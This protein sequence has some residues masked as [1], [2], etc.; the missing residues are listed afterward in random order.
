MTR[1]QRI[2]T[3]EYFESYNLLIKDYHHTQQVE[4]MNIVVCGIL[5]N[6]Q[7]KYLLNQR[8]IVRKKVDESNNT[9]FKLSLKGKEKLRQL[10]GKEQYFKQKIK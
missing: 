9:W 8:A 10:K 7:I 6:Y 4:Q 5:T 2:E 1:K 3:L